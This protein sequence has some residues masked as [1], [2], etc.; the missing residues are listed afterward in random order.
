M[1]IELTLIIDIYREDLS[2][3]KILKILK[4]SLIESLKEDKKNQDPHQKNSL[5]DCDIN[6]SSNSIN[7]LSRSYNQFINNL[8]N[9]AIILDGGEVVLEED[10]EKKNIILLELEEKDKE[11]Q[12]MY[13]LLVLTY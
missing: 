10:S 12:N 13:T 8:D 1:D 2:L 7:N 6:S 9:S 5:L 11:L 3:L 4:I